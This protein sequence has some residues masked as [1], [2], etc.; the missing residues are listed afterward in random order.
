MGSLG[1][2]TKGLLSIRRDSRRVPTGPPWAAI[3][4]APR[5]TPTALRYQPDRRKVLTSVSPLAET[6]V[7][8]TWFKG[9]L[10]IRNAGPRPGFLHLR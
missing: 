1:N 7:Y 10:R 5:L 6:G 4:I 3:P 8:L 9:F 2:G